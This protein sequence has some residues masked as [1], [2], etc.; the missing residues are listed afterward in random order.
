MN[1]TAASGPIATKFYLNHH[2]VAE[3]AA[4]G[5]VPDRIR[6][7]DS[8]ATDSSHMVIMGENIRPKK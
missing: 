1:I 8:M 3:K 7:L 2:W 5:F 4:S 6:T